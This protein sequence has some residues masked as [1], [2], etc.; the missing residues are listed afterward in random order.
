GSPDIYQ[1]PDRDPNRSIHFITCHD[2]FTL[3]DLVSYNDKHNLA[4]GEFNRDGANDNFCW[5]CGVEG[6]TDD[7][8]VAALRLRQIKNLLTLLFFSQGTPM[9]LMGDEV[10][11]SQQGNNNAYCQDNPLSWFD[12]DAVEDHRALLRFIQTLIHIIQSHEAFKVEHLLTVTDSWSRQPH[13]V[14]HGV[15][16]GSP[17]WGGNSHT[18]A[19]TLRHPEAKEQFHVMLNAYWEALEFELPDLEPGLRWHQLVD[20]AAV[21]PHDVFTPE[22]APVWQQ[23]TYPVIARASAVLVAR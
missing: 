9:L 7:P 19:F 21:V 6:P 23:T 1:E 18:L 20:T 13:I 16:L 12:W 15:Q 22:T 5:N 10:R 14:W 2:G 3:N 4:N 8:A 11:R 17:D